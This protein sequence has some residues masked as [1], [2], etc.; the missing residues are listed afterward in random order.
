MLSLPRTFHGWAS[1]DAPDSGE[2]SLEHGRSQA[3]RLRVLLTRV[4]RG[5]EEN[6]ARQLSHSAVGECGS[7]S[8]QVTT[9]IAPC[10]QKRIE[11]D[12]AQGHDDAQAAEQ[13]DLLDQVW[14]TGGE[15]SPGGLVAWWG[16]PDGRRDVAIPERE[17]IVAVTRPGLIG[18]PRTIQSTVQEVPAPVTCEDPACPIAPLG[19]RREADQQ[20]SRIRIAEARD[21]FSPV[22]LVAVPPDLLPRHPLP[23]LHQARAATAVHHFSLDDLEGID[24]PSSRHTVTGP[25]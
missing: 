4:I 11:G 14:P 6:A 18:E 12:P 9:G 20:Q 25:S 17:T 19:R 23:I 22:F 3:S 8:R 7:G 2:D 15:F 5:Q 10:P 24:P 1:Q 21:R 16:T 13:A